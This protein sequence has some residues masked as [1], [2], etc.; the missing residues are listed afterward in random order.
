MI[1]STPTKGLLAAAIMT[2]GAVAYSNSSD[3]SGG[4]LGARIGH[5]YNLESCADG[6]LKCDKD[7]TGYGIFAGYD[8]SP[9]WG[10]E[11]S[12]NDI[13][14]SHAVY[15]AVSLKGELHET[16]LAVRY[17]YPGYSRFRFY[18]KAGVAFWEA[19]VTGFN[20]HMK[21]SGSR[22]LVG[23]GL[24]YSLSPHWT[25][26]LEYQHI[27]KIGNSQMGHAHPNFL[28]LALV[29]N[30]SPREKPAP[31]HVPVQ[32][33]PVQTPPPQPRPAEPPREQRIVVDE[34]RQGP[35]FEFDRADIRNTAAIDVVAD[36]LLKNPA[37]DVRII[38]HTDSRGAA[39]YNQRLSERRAEA[40][41]RYLQNKGVSARRITSVGQGESHPVADNQTDSGRAQNRR[42][43]FVITGTKTAP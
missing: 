3:Y 42:V 41:A 30:F 21:D 32:A 8:F 13:G 37:L 24:E 11:L 34:Q 7:D 28:S 22:P 40:V 23:L 25:T 6:Y 43:E 29:W 4:Y 20:T 17:T 9:N 38:G 1:R 27:D 31:R 2:Y 18:G 26:R 19:K 10:L 5:S 12:Y 15:P 39:D 33:A 14:D 36:Q 16:D 35:L